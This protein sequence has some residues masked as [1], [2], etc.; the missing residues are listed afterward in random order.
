[1]NTFNCKYGCGFEVS[2]ENPVHMCLPDG[3]RHK[4]VMMIY[5]MNSSHGKNSDLG[6]RKRFGSR[7][8][9]NK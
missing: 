7:S 4:G 2:I 6:Y 8:R 3:T 9:A 5:M 1:V